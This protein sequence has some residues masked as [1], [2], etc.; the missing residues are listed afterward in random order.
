MPWTISISELAIY[1]QKVIFFPCSLCIAYLIK[2]L[3]L[4][5]AL[6]SES[7]EFHAKIAHRKCT[8][9]LALCPAVAGR[10]VPVPGAIFEEC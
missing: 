5:V 4:C 9:G 1:F 10:L 6:I 7:Q 2:I 3:Q 8:E